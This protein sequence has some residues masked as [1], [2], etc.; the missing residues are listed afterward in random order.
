VTRASWSRGAVTDD[1][2]QERFDLELHR[3][4]GEFR[5][6]EE[7]GPQRIEE[8]RRLHA[9]TPERPLAEIELRDLAKAQ[10]VGICRFRRRPRGAEHLLLVLV[11]LAK[12]VLEQDVPGQPHLLESLDGRVGDRREEPRVV[13]RAA[14]TV[15]RDPLGSAWPARRRCSGD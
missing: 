13:L 9:I 11:Q 1:R 14:R 3:Q 12:A 5:R 4:P 10:H 6:R 7:H 8:V 15:A 2:R